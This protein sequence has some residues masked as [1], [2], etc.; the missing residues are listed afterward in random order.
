MANPAKR[1][2]G[3]GVERFTFGAFLVTPE[4]R[5]AFETCADIA[6]SRLGTAQPVVIVGPSGSGKTHLLYAVANRVRQKPNSG[7]VCIGARHF[8]DAARSLAHDP[9]P[10]TRVRRVLLLVDQLDSFEDDAA[11]VE[12]LID[13][14]LDAGQGVIVASQKSPSGL[15]RY[16]EAFRE[17][18]SHGTALRVRPRSSNGHAAHNGGAPAATAQA[19]SKGS[20][21]AAADAEHLAIDAAS[22]A[23]PGTWA[24]VRTELG[25]AYEQLQWALG[26][27][28]RL[29]AENARHA[30]HPGILDRRDQNARHMLDQ[31]EHLLHQ[32]QASRRE[33]EALHSAHARQLDELRQLSVAPDAERNAA[34]GFVDEPNTPP[35]VAGDA[36]VELQRLREDNQRLANELKDARNEIDRVKYSLVKA[37]AERDTERTRLRRAHDA[38]AG[39]GAPPPTAPVTKRYQIEE[40]GEGEAAPESPIEG[41]LPMAD[42]E[43]AA[44]AARQDVANGANESTEARPPRRASVHHVEDLDSARD[45]L[46]DPFD[47]SDADDAKRP[48]DLA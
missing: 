8:P 14:F 33:F 32:L 20:N 47:F 6:N 13:A 2:P 29:R 11:D 45:L 10:L 18:L 38:L 7:L 24:A 21:G 42:L 48:D 12:L 17:R 9:S 22:V 30:E 5:A 36:F 34:F 39:S 31:A 25:H 23:D 44:R 1:S 43:N 15:G 19:K 41:P 28:E 46:G 26:E 40:A 16:S 35:M 4:N 37:R 27:I 3:S